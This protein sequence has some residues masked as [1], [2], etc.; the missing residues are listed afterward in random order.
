MSATTSATSDTD[1]TAGRPSAHRWWVMVLCLAAFTM[2]SVDRSTW[3]PASVFVGEDLRVPLAS[4]GAFATAYYVGY[5]I[6]NGLGGFSTDR[7]GGR[8][9]MSVSLLGAG[10]FMTVFGSTTSATVGIAVQAVIGLFAGAEYSAG[11]T[12]LAS[13]FEPREL[14]LVM[15]IYTTAT[16]LGTMIANGIVPWLITQSGWETSYHLFGV[17]SIVV[18]VVCFAVVRSGPQLPDR[19]TAPSR[20]PLVG[21]REIGRNR[22]LVLLG[23]A[24]F[25]GFWGTYGFITWSNALMIRGHGIDPTT[26]GMV[27]VVFAGVAVIGKPLVGWIADRCGGARKVPAM[28]ILGLFVV[29]LLVFGTLG[30]A[31]AFLLAA[32]LLGLAAYAYLPLLVAMIPRLATQGTTGSA[33][34]MTNALWQLGSVLVPLAVGAVFSSTRSFGAAFGCLAI[35]PAIGLILM[36][37]VREPWRA[38]D[39]AEDAAAEVDR[40][41]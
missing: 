27:V 8:V 12:L 24:G 40:S 16:S 7:F 32:P 25:G 34:G 18:A 28:V 38:Q 20:S 11:V 4:L 17:I 31:T 13:W 14:G 19:S 35:G 39:A 26:A 23:L 36:F 9:T 6:A 37:F 30:S 3:G 5:V 2:T 41:A 15:G 29:M 21:L 10:A 22:D 33:A 1:A